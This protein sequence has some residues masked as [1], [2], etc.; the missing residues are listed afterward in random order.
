MV[1]VVG[2]TNAAATATS[3]TATP[4]MFAISS[5]IELSLALD[6]VVLSL[7]APF[8]LS[9][10]PNRGGPLSL[11]CEGWLDHTGCTLTPSARQDHNTYDH[12]EVLRKI[13]NLYVRHPPYRSNTL[14]S[15]RGEP[16]R[17]VVLLVLPLSALG[18]RSGSTQ[19]ALCGSEGQRES[20]VQ[21]S[22]SKEGVNEAPDCHRNRQLLFVLR[23]GEQGGALAIQVSAEREGDEARAKT[24]CVRGYHSCRIKVWATAVFCTRGPA[25]EKT[26]AVNTAQT[27]NT[28][29]KLSCVVSNNPPQEC[30][31]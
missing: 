7:P 22:L 20:V 11:A 4:K 12:R 13:L 19:H 2:G 1:V 14:R 15:P 18:E 8:S 31:T 5:A 27:P 10:S 24:W 16:T 6:C 30:D 29:M 26:L 9:R 17:R 23:E 28:L 21:G 25:V 3:E